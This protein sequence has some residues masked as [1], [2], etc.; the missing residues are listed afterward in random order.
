MYACF[1]DVGDLGAAS[2]CAAADL[3]VLGVCFTIDIV[4]KIAYTV[5]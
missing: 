3:F 2:L 4:R 1:G 5:V